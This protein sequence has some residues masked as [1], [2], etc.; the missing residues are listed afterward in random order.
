MNHADIYNSKSFRQYN[1]ANRI[2]DHIFNNEKPHPVKVNTF[3]WNWYVKALKRKIKNYSLARKR[4]AT[5]LYNSTNV[6]RT[7][8]HWVYTYLRNAIPL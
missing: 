6:R 5:L 2:T 1:N 3:I 8:F 7:L 4:I